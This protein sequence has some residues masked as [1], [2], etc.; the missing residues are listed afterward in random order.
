MTGSGAGIERSLGRSQISMN[1]AAGSDIAGFFRKADR[2]GEY[3]CGFNGIAG[4]QE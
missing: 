3:F 1:L 2:M 4:V